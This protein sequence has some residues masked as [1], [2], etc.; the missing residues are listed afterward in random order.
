MGTKG[1]MERIERLGLE[2]SKISD[3][4]IRVG[5]GSLKGG[6]DTPAHGTHENGYEIDFRPFRK[7][8]TNT[9]IT[10]QD[11]NYD[12]D[13]TRKFIALVKTIY[14]NS[15]I[16]FN[17]PVLIKEGLTK[18]WANHDNHLHIKFRDTE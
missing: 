13:A 8:G 5:H 4:P 17:D 6:G 9:G 14:P 15:T 2:W 16:L 18:Q 10:W 11:K 12:R 7:D 3:V 1:T